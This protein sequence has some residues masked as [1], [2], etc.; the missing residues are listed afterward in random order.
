MSALY[1]SAEAS[2]KKGPGESRL[3]RWLELKLGAPK[4]H[5]PSS[6]RVGGICW[7]GA[8]SHFPVFTATS[9]RS[10]LA[11]GAGR[12]VPS[13]FL[14]QSSHCLSDSPRGGRGGGAAG[15]SL[16]G[17]INPW[18][19]SS[20]PALRSAPCKLFLI[21]LHTNFPRGSAGKEPACQCRRHRRHGFNPW[22][23]KIPWR[24]K[25]QPTPVFFPEKS[26]GQRSLA[27]YSPKGHK[28]SYATE[29]THTHTHTHTHTAQLY[30][31]GATDTSMRTRERV[32]CGTILLSLGTAAP[33]GGLA[34]LPRVSCSQRQASP[35]L[36]ALRGASSPRMRPSLVTFSFC[37]CQ[38]AQD[39]HKTTSV[40]KATDSILC[41]SCPQVHVL[42]PTLQCDG[43]LRC[44]LWGVFRS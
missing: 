35:F 36:T 15:A 2:S 12:E 10:W 44:S 4:P 34:G 16:L 1:W 33:S 9:A 20:S 8:G 37:W 43:V 26:H 24:R 38:K 41:P 6:P 18:L 32:T 31:A 22:V 42:K 3:H 13:R 40:D 28:E 25:W 5:S 11:A 17:R 29:Y 39:P 30:E 7:Q 14:S 21:L 19:L 23:R 27:D